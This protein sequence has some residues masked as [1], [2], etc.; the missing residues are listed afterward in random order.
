MYFLP[1][2]QERW[3]ARGWFLVLPACRYG[4]ELQGEFQKK[5]NRSTFNE[6]FL[7]YAASSNFRRRHV[8]R[9]RSLLKSDGVYRVMQE[10][11]VFSLSRIVF[12]G[13]LKLNSG[14][15]NERPSRDFPNDE[16][17]A[18]KRTGE[19]CTLN[20]DTPVAENL[21]SILF[22]VKSSLTD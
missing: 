5:G 8:Y 13:W 1:Q 14:Q 2:F 11:G 7:P 16:R 22:C 20:R 21:C 3:R 18:R 17:S 19:V 12:D 4:G 15:L 6:C 10:S 9:S